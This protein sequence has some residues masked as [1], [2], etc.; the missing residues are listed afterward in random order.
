MA[1]I[2]IIETCSDCPFFQDAYVS[3]GKLREYCTKEGKPVPWKRG[4]LR[5]RGCYPIPDFCQL[6]NKENNEHKDL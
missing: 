6:T 3:W 1:K 2:L 5:N 4:G